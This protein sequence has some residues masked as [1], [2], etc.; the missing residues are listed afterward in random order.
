M[1]YYYIIFPKHFA[2]PS[3]FFMVYNRET[4]AAAWESATYEDAETCTEA[5]EDVTEQFNKEK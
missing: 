2:D 1:K 3:C 4:G 5:A